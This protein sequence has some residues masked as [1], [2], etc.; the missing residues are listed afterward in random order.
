[1]YITGINPAADWTST[2]EFKLGTMGAVMGAYG[3]TM[4]RYVKLRNETATVAVVAGDM[5]AYL[6]SPAAGSG[7]TLND[8][9][10]TVVSDNT[11][12]ATKPIAAGMA[13]A[14]VAGVAS[15][16]YYG[17][18]Q[19]G[20][21]AIVNQ[22]IAGTPADGDGLFLSTTDKTLTLATATDDPICAYAV[23]ESAKM[24]RLACW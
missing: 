9:F 8:E 22:T 11:D 5:L 18:V 17:W 24:V 15:T 3:M 1:M 14:S 10:H 21:F 6:A 12:A 23:D 20:G 16:A 4:Y 19:C 7:A 13:G 2:P